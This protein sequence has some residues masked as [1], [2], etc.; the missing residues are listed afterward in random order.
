VYIGDS[1]SHG[2]RSPVSWDVRKP[3]NWDDYLDRQLAA[4]GVRHVDYDT[5]NGRSMTDHRLEYDERNDREVNISTR[6]TI[7]A[8]L[9]AGFRGCWII[10]VGLA[11]AANTDGD[12]RSLTERLHGTL[13]LLRGQRVL[14]TTGRTGFP[15]TSQKEFDI[16]TWRAVLYAAQRHYDFKIYDWAGEI[17]DSQFVADKVHYTQAGSAHRAQATAAAVAAAFPK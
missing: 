3:P 14:W 4:R 11:D 6:E 15:S 17:D 10:A 12:A 1:T 5:R 9:A 2:M 13:D 8:K 16:Q 7:K